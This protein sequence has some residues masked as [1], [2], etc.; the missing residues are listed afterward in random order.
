MM[1][2]DLLADARQVAYDDSCES[3]G[4]FRYGMELLHPEISLEQIKDLWAEVTAA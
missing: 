4:D 2:P 3:A 1:N